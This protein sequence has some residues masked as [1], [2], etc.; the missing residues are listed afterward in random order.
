M[1]ALRGVPGSFQRS[2]DHDQV[3]DEGK[4]VRFSRTKVVLMCSTSGV[5]VGRVESA[6]TGGEVGCLASCVGRGPRVRPGD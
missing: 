6:D 5:I 3:D 4:R 1:R 2:Y